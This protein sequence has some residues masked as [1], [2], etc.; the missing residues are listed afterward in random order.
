MIINLSNGIAETSPKI[1]SPG[2]HGP[3]WTTGCKHHCNTGLDPIE[4]THC[5][6]RFCYFSFKVRAP[7]RMPAGLM[8]PLLMPAPS[9]GEV[10]LAASQGLSPSPIA[11]SAVPLVTRWAKVASRLSP[12]ATM[13][14]RVPTGLMAQLLKSA[15]SPGG[16]GTWASKGR[17]PKTIASSVVSKMTMWATVAS[18]LSRVA[19]MWWRVSTLSNNTL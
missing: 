5:T 10:G 7:A 15:P 17:S 1:T 2:C 12:M 19:T 13:W 16:V 18:P 9:H 14:W 8:A 4:Q 3:C 11:S 6:P